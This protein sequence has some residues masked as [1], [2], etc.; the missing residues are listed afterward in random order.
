MRKRK[1]DGESLF[2][3]LIF[4]ATAQLT[5]GEEPKDEALS[6]APRKPLNGS[7]EDLEELGNSAENEDISTGVGHCDL[8]PVDNNERDPQKARIPHTNNSSGHSTKWKKEMDGAAV[9]MRNS[10]AEMLNAKNR[11]A[12]SGKAKDLNIISGADATKA[13]FNREDRSSP[14]FRDQVVTP[15]PG[16][17]NRFRASYTPA[18]RGKSP[19]PTQNAAP[20]TQAD[21]K[22]ETRG[23]RSKVTENAS[24]TG[25]TVGFEETMAA[26][27]KAKQN[28]DVRKCI[29]AE[30]ATPVRIKNANYEIIP[31]HSDMKS[32][33]H[34]SEVTSQLHAVMEA[35][36]KAVEFIHARTQHRKKLARKYDK[37]YRER[38]KAKS[39]ELKRRAHELEEQVKVL[40]KSAQDDAK[41]VGP[42]SKLAKRPRMATGFP[43]SRSE[44][45]DY[46]LYNGSYYKRISAEHVP[47]ESA[48]TTVIDHQS[49]TFRTESQGPTSGQQEDAINSELNSSKMRASSNRT[50]NISKKQKKQEPQAQPNKRTPMPVVKASLAPAKAIPTVAALSGPVGVTQSQIMGS[51]IPQSSPMQ[52][53]ASATIVPV[54][55]FTGVPQAHVFQHHLAS[56]SIS[57]QMHYMQQQNIQKV[58]QRIQQQQIRDQ[59]TR[60]MEQLRNAYAEYKLKCPVCGKILSSVSSRNRHLNTHCRP[61]M[62]QCATC[63]AVFPNKP[64]LK[65]HQEKSHGLATNSQTSGLSKSSQRSSTK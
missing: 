19:S 42:A 60:E 48:I 3:S 65:K 45:V 52:Q 58:Q 16:T 63:N 22:S 37:A 13:I 55:P 49:S 6:V 57:Q 31:L 8:G 28:S 23:S 36:R 53:I 56:Q 20:R 62:H 14:P 51:H 27:Q 18:V 61:K 12:K 33:Q 1:R 41:N 64:A 38:A 25:E 54:I 11:F 17:Y 10:N 59:R 26:T 40:K 21:S 30:L 15:R 46:I 44:P 43:G 32:G 24:S 47:T 4:A 7:R 50:K 29:S 5:K 39:E 9:R 2:E 34:P 35:N